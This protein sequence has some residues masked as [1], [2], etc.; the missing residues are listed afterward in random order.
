MQ[1]S[2]MQSRI[3]KIIKIN[4][5]SLRE[6]WDNFKHT[7]IH[8][9]TRRRRKKG[10]EKIFEEIIPENSPNVQKESL[11]QIQEA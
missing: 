1:K 7:N 8:R 3:K 11:T 10:P 2:L 4:E 6:L 5:D 9:G